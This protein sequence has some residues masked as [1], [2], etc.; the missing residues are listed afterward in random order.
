[1]YTA[2]PISSKS[3]TRDGHTDGE[4]DRDTQGARHNAS[5]WRGSHINMEG[6]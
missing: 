5:Y 2:Y 4:M 1:M 3:K 6:S